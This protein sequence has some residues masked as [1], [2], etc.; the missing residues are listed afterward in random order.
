MYVH[1]VP[2]H[3]YSSRVKDLSNAIDCVFDFNL[4]RI[5]CKSHDALFS[6]V[7]KSELYLCTRHCTV[8]MKL[9]LITSFDILHVLA[10]SDVF[11]DVSVI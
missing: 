7:Q 2:C 9:I 11:L 5:S 10:Y 3:V 6:N 4:S 1:K 8:C